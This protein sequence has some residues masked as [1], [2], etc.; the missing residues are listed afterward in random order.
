MNLRSCQLNERRYGIGMKFNSLAAADDLSAVAGL[1][2]SGIPCDYGSIV[3]FPGDMEIFPGDGPVPSMFPRRGLNNKAD[4]DG[5]FFFSHV[6]GGI[7]PVYCLVRG[8]EALAVPIN[9]PVRCIPADEIAITGIP[10]VYHLAC[11]VVDR[12][13]PDP[14]RGRHQ[15]TVFDWLCQN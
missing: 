15:G 3:I 2:P 9:L 13:Q 7:R 11:A 5:W 4:G 6:I 10:V 1:H 8:I 12:G 14:D